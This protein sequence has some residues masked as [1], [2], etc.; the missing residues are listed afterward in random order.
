MATATAK[1]ILDRDYRI[2]PTDPRL[3]GSFLEHLGR[4]V[5]DGIYEPGHPAADAAGFRRDV[6]ELVRELGVTVVRYPGGNFVSGYDWE[7]G[8]GPRAARPRRLEPA[9]KSIETN[10]FGTDEFIAWCRAAEV[11]P[12]LAVNLGTRGADA[13]RAL[14]E[15]CNHPGGTRWSD[16]R[17]QNGATAPHG[18]KLWCLGNEMDGPWQMGHKTAAEYGRLACETGRLMKMVDSK[19]ELVACG[20]SYCGM[21]T[22]GEWE[23]TALHEC[24]EQVDYVSLHTY[25]G[26][27][28]QDAASFLAKPEE[29]GEYIESVVALCD[30]AAARKKQKRRLMLSF[31]EWNV[32]YHS[33]TAD[34]QR[35]P[36]TV[37]PPILEDAY[38]FLDALVVG[39]ML[40]QLINHADRVKV[41]CLAQLVNVIAPIMTQKGGPAWRQTIFHPFAQTA[42]WGQGEVLR[43]VLNTPRHDCK[44]R[45]GVPTVSCAAVWRPE[46]EELSIFALNRDLAAP[47]ELCVD[48]RAFGSLG[49]VEWESLQS[50]DLAA[51]NTASVPDRVKP[52]F[53]AGAQLKKGELAVQLPAASWNVL[54]LSK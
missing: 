30:A 28:D 16:L 20:S 8:V 18:I 9:W 31:D 47:V 23:L 43:P 11:E 19:L 51:V 29:M 52:Q 1:L 27:R 13:A 41:A 49:R 37:A 5:Y 4:A 10:E 53:Q 36:W 46:V 32:W 42:R 17:R 14:V 44:Q 2:G 25:Y 40:I 54:R 39:G 34:A 24:Y 33:Q 45:Q 48:L 22:F 6:L 35:E 15:Y 7:D 12:L 3:Y 50:S 26:N 21:P 38:D